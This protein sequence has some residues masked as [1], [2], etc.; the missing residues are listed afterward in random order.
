MKIVQPEI[1][2][3]FLRYIYPYMTAVDFCF[4]CLIQN[5]V[6][7]ALTLFDFFFSVIKNNPQLTKTM[8]TTFKLFDDCVKI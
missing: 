3:A 8:A 2:G 7:K 1:S 5:Y 6:E 4:V